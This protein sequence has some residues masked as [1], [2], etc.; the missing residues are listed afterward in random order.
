MPDTVRH[1][2]YQLLDYVSTKRWEVLKEPWR[3]DLKAI[4]L[5]LLMGG[6]KPILEEKRYIKEKAVQV[7][8]GCLH[9]VLSCNAL[10]QTL[11]V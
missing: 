3:T 9:A 4:A 8:L 10:Q 7:A 2:G 11:T 1:F 6:T 5:S